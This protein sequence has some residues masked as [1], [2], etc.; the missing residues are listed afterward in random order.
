MDAVMKNQQVEKDEVETRLVERGLKPFDTFFAPETGWKIVS[1]FRY[2][3][4][5]L[6]EIVIDRRSPDSMRPRVDAAL[7][8]LAAA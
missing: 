1:K 5:R 4:G 3:D 8:T 6:G 2:P 7:A